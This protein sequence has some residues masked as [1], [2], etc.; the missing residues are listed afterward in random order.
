MR[1]GAGEPLLGM[2]S[3]VEAVAEAVAEVVP[4]HNCSAVAGMTADW[5]V[6]AI[7]SEERFLRGSRFLIQVPHRMSSSFL[8]FYGTFQLL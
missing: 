6:G 1:R 4:K 2:E 7:S 5:P 3:A 8:F